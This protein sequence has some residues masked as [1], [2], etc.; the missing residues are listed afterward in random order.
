MK[1]S[2]VKNNYL[3]CF[4]SLF[5]VSIGFSQETILQGK[6]TDTKNTALPYVN[7]GIPMKHTGTV[8][9][10][11]GIYKLKISSNTTK[12]DSVVFSYIGYKTIKMTV[13]E[14]DNHKNSLIQMEMEENQLEEVV[15]KTKKLKDKKLG[16]SSTG[17]GLLHYNFYTTKEKEVDDRLSKELGMKFKLRKNCRL[18]KFNFA[19]SQNEFKTLKFRINIY[20]LVDDQPKDLL[21]SD[22]ILFDIKNEKIDWKSIDLNQYNIY[23]KE[24]LNDFLLTIQW[25]NSEKSKED[26]KFFAIHANKSPLHKVYY[27]EK[28]M[29]SWKTQTGGLSMY[30]DARCSN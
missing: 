7:I 17:L 4:F 21:I 30:L 23:L 24:E 10:E 1:I 12:N 9:N 6:V 8:S 19:I 22:N 26:S 18:E 5:L 15:F 20:N 27:R 28:A 13:A 11:N 29:D 16:T 25:V 2:K 3:S 14:L